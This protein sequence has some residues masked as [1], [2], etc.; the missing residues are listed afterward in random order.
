MS[1]QPPESAL[2]KSRRHLP[3]W[4]LVGSTYF[5][6]WRCVRGFVLDPADRDLVIA[7]LEHWDGTR[8][9]LF[10]AT[11]MPDHVHVLL[12]PLAGPAGTHRLRDIVR[13]AK[14]YSARRVNERR[15]RRGSVWQDERR[16][17][18]IRGQ[19]EFVATWNYIRQN[20]VD[21]GL[22]CGAHEYRWL[23]EKRTEQ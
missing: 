23:V 6:T 20:A 15:H 5:V 14:A 3:H 21:R 1:D 11:V 12:K 8:Y 7:N 4:E 17:R 13:T 22:V 16:D 2:T 9:L 19:R 18:I 10:A